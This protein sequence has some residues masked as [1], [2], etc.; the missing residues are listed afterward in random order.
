MAKQ[1]KKKPTKQA[2]RWFKKTRGSYLANSW[3]GIF[4]YAVYLLFLVGSLVYNVRQTSDLAV[5]FLA[6]AVEWLLAA[7]V[8]TWVA[9]Q[10]S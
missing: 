7:I 10:K 4:L 1:T 9:Q 6:T 3:E 5:I 8:I 2:D